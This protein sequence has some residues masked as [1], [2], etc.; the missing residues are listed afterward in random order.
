[1]GGLI[2]VTAELGANLKDF[3]GTLPRTFA[4]PIRKSI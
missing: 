2:L 3:P 1:M 4:M